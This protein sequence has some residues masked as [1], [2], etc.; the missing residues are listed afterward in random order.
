LLKPISVVFLTRPKIKIYLFGIAARPIEKLA[1]QIIVF[2]FQTI[3]LLLKN[4]EAR[5][6]FDRVR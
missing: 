3:F 1:A 5:R 2:A 4:S 6:N